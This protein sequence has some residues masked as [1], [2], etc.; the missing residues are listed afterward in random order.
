MSIDIKDLKNK[1]VKELYKELEEAKK[2]LL[3]LK[4]EIAQS[5]VKNYQEVASSRK[6]IARILTIIQEKQWQE[7]E[8]LEKEKEEKDGK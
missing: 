6:N 1:S 4:F 7:F 8:K 2:N 3:K 5:K